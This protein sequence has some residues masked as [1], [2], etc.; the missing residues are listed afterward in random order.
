MI[1]K[2]YKRIHNKYSTLFKFIFF[3]RYLF[4]I[5]FLSVV[6]FLSIPYFFDFEKKDAIIKNYLLE[7]YGITIIKYKNIKY[8]SLPRPNLEI[9]NI[10]ANIQKNSIRMSIGSLNIYPNLL[11]IYNYE[12]F[13]ATKIVLDKNK[14]LLSD[15]DLKI[16]IN[17]IYNLKNKLS[18]KNLDLRINTNN[19]S[20]INFKKI[21]FS[22]YGYNKNIF[23][24][25]LLDKK[26]KISISDN[27][28][29]INLKL[30]KTG[31]L[32]SKLLNSNLKFNFEYDD[33]KIKIYNSYFRN[34][35]LSFNNKGTITYQPFFSSNLIINIDDINMKFLKNINID[36][37]FFSKD[38]IKRFNT[39][40]EINFK[41]KKL[42]RNLIDDLNLNINIA[43]GR[44]VYQ[45]KIFISDNFLK[46][47][48]DINLLEEFP[49]LYF[50]CST[51]FKDQK[52]FFK[53]LKIKYK[54][55]KELSKINFMGNINILNNKINFKNITVNQDYEATKEDLNYFKQSFENIFF[56]KDFLNIFNYEKIKEFILEI[57]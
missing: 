42:S 8:N 24:G 44:L 48:G 54:N 2:I 45:K 19:S 22:N 14:I 36:K 25:E 4:G 26:L 56:D 3:L 30:L 43:Y 31:V 12:N 23:I 6:L 20:L 21:N 18:F 9:Q 33:K 16:L 28:N 11:N 47:Q 55:K 38:L 17:Y 34:R 15:L 50:D 57:S 37:I 1:N 29:Q 10:D 40:N 46:C 51:V 27:F 32:K 39:K 7:N 52:K 41:S 5:F 35:N 13:K 53:K 49:I